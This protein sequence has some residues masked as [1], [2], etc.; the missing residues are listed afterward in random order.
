MDEADLA[1]EMES[2]F[3]RHSL[4]AARGPA[5]NRPSKTHCTECGEKIP[6]KRREMMPGCE[7][8]VRCQTIFEQPG[9]Y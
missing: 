3:F 1:Q 9:G 5:Q 7:R 6:E 4:A 2:L 8:C